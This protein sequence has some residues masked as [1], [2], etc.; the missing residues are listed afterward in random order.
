MLATAAQVDPEAAEL[1]AQIRRQRFTR[2]SRIVAALHGTGALD[3]DLGT[4]E[5]DNIVYALLSPEVHQIPRSS[6]LAR[7]PL[8]ALDRA[9]PDHALAHRLACPRRAGW[10][11]QG[12]HVVAAA[13]PLSATSAEPLTPSTA[14]AEMCANRANQPPDAGMVITARGPGAAGPTE[15]ADL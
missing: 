4:D 5:A 2:Q 9:R 15:P 1:L 13:P 11:I 6:G 14:P 8:R 3:P 12:E 7:R 10:Q